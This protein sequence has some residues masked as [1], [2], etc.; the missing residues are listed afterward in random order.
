MK[1]FVF[2][3]A[4]LVV[5]L[6][7]GFVAGIANTTR[8]SGLAPPALSHSRKAQTADKLK[9]QADNP[10]KSNVASPIS[11]SPHLQNEQDTH[12]AFLRGSGKAGNDTIPVAKN[13]K[14]YS[15]LVTLASAN[16]LTGIDQLHL[17]GSIWSEPSGTKVRIIDAGFITSEIRVL[18]GRY[19][20]R[21]CIVA[22]RFISH[23]QPFASSTIAIPKDVSYTTIDSSTSP[24]G[25]GSIDIRLNK[26]VSKNTLQAISS[27]IQA[28]IPTKRLILYWLPG[29]TVGTGAWATARLLPF[30]PGIKIDILGM[31]AKQFTK[32]AE[33]HHSSDNRKVI[34]RWVDTTPYGGGVITIFRKNGT[35]YLQQRG[36]MDLDEKLAEKPSPLGRWF[37]I[38]GGSRVGDSTVKWVI[39]SDGNLQIRDNQGLITTA[40]KLQ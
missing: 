17:T 16:D 36:N 18:S 12:I 30:H 19:S 20:G 31:T 33:K 37:D 39:G 40:K 14:V 4:M 6:F 23:K 34:G 26:R 9:A 3:A 35:F 24:D 32:V 7:F 27:K 2:G 22:T 25:S 8:P 29:M 1:T 28:K 15:R 5:G 11:S 10:A 38:V 21:D 13:E